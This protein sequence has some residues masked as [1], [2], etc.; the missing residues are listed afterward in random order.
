VKKKSEILIKD[1]TL[2]LGGG[3]SS[4]EDNKIKQLITG[5]LY[6]EA[7][8]DVTKLY[9]Q[10]SLAITIE[11]ADIENESTIRGLLT[12][13]TRTPAEKAEEAIKFVEKKIEH[14]LRDAMA[15]MEAQEK[16]EIEIKSIRDETDSGIQIDWESYFAEQAPK[17]EEE[18]TSEVEPTI[19]KSR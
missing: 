4:A 12:D 8:G 17:T 11:L 10:V 18:S 7:K 6:K 14:G 1:Y 15:S 19:E 13:S 5:Q 2:D 16:T 9:T 3:S